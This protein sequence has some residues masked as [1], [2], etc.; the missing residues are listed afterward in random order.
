MLTED[1]EAATP[2]ALPAF[3]PS[4]AG[5]TH[6]LP[7]TVLVQVRLH[8]VGGRY[9]VSCVTRIDSRHSIACVPHKCPS[10]CIIDHYM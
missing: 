4:G 9:Q 1:D 3:I 8:M 7:D 2:P 6:T 10:L 5:T